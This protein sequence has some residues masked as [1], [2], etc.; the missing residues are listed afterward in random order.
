MNMPASNLH[1]LVPVHMLF[2]VRV[3]TGAN[4]VTDICNTVFVVRPPPVI[5][6]KHLLQ[7]L[8]SFLMQ[9]LNQRTIIM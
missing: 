6:K 3:L 1:L 9:Y 4:T 5:Y 2:F 8:H 7:N